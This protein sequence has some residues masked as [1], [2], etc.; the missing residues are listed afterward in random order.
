MT[1]HP[2]LLCS[3]ERP[4]AIKNDGQGG[5]TIVLTWD[6]T[7]LDTIHLISKHYKNC[8]LLV[9]FVKPQ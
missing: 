7:Q 6:E 9:T 2:V 3:I 1:E 4:N 5:G 8:E